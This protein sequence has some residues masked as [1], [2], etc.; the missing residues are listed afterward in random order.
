[1]NYKANRMGGYFIM[2]NTPLREKEMSL[3]AKGLL[4]FMFSV[5]KESWKF[6]VEGLAKVMKENE[7]SIR[8]AIQEL[9]EFGYLKRR[10]VRNSAGQIQWFYDFYDV[11]FFDNDKTHA[12]EN[13]PLR[14]IHPLKT[15]PLENPRYG[16]SEDIRNNKK[17][18]TN[19]EITNKELSINCKKERSAGAYEEILQKLPNEELKVALREYIKMR[20]MNKRPLT[21]YALETL[22]KKLFTMT[23]KTEEMIE[24]VNQATV[25]TWND[26]FEVKPQ[27]QPKEQTK[28]FANV[29]GFIDMA[30][31]M[32]KGELNE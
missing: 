27:S 3:K 8:S 28:K 10:K 5:D 32:Q 1:M 14:N 17:E 15:P 4:C 6:S 24:I 9:E 25:R 29:G 20:I 7:T 12:M 13:P 19:K 18:I 22:I 2:G 26:F 16:L 23:N 30:I 21:N 31:E 11:P